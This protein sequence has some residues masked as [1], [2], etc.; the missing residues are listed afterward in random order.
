MLTVMYEVVPIHMIIVKHA[1]YWITK[2]ASNLNSTKTNFF[3]II[4]SCLFTVKTIKDYLLTIYC[5][6]S[7]KIVINLKTLHSKRAILGIVIIIIMKKTLTLRILVT[8]R[9]SLNL[10]RCYQMNLLAQMNHLDWDMLWLHLLLYLIVT[11]N[12]LLKKPSLILTIS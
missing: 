2:S 5:N 3:E 6:Q 4:S 9:F 12:T 10:M 8:M 1:R 11:K 7:N